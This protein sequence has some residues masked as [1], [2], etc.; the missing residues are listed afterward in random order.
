MALRDRRASRR[1]FGLG[2]LAAGVIGGAACSGGSPTAL[3]ESLDDR[4]VS[5]VRAANPLYRQVIRASDAS[6]PLDLDVNGL[7]PLGPNED[8]ELWLIV[9]GRPMSGGVFDVNEDGEMETLELRAH[10]DTTAMAVT[11]EPSPDADPNPSNRPVLAGDVDG[12][13]M[14]VLD[15]D[16]SYLDGAAPVE[17]APVGRVMLEPKMG[18]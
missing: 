14:I 5:T 8:Y 7:V 4:S 17:G 10:P 1:V 13:G 15:S 9:D 2:V 11:I 16:H 18:E 3:P 6:I 12:A